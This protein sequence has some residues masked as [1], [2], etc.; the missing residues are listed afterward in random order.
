MPP[1]VH[2]VEFPSWL[3]SASGR[4]A[5]AD[6]LRL[7]LGSNSNTWQTDG[8]SGLQMTHCGVTLNTVSMEAGDTYKSGGHLQMAGMQRSVCQE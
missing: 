7:T 3:Q 4:L 6:R 2:V 1:S 5:K 8:W